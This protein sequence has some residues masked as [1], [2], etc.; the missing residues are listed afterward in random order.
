MSVANMQKTARDTKRAIPEWSGSSPSAFAHSRSNST[1][2][3][4][5]PAASSVI[6]SVV[7][8]GRSRSGSSQSAFNTSKA[9]RLGAPGAGAS[10]LVTT[11]TGTSE[12]RS[13][14]SNS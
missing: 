9:V 1:T 7:R 11:R 14:R 10:R 3:P 13:V 6:C 12:V 5:N 8:T 4:N 2:S